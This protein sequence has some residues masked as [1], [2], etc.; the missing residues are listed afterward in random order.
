MQCLVRC[1]LN[2]T[3]GEL[4]IELMI[5]VCD[6]GAI[7]ERYFVVVDVIVGRKVSLECPGLEIDAEDLRLACRKERE[8]TTD[9]RHCGR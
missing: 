7:L 3:G 1:L 8:M 5:R 4:G 2:H 6:G 9:L